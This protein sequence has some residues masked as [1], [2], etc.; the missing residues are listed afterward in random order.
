VRVSLPGSP[1]RHWHSQKSESSGAGRNSNVYGQCARAD[2]RCLVL[3]VGAERSFARAAAQRPQ[4]L[5]DEYKPLDVM[6]LKTCG[7]VC[8]IAPD[9]NYGLFLPSPNGTRVPPRVV[10]DLS[11]GGTYVRAASSVT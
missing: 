10:R 6:K 9:V 5:R 7:L 2:Q 8:V 1:R 3:S 11:L 4:S